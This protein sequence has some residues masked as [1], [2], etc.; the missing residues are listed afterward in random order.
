MTKILSQD[1]LY[2]SLEPPEHKSELQDTTLLVEFMA[3]FKCSTITE[4]NQH[5]N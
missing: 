2:P 5:H 3:R 4:T 1:S